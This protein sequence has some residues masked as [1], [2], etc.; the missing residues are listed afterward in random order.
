MSV[1][2]TIWK[3]VSGNIWGVWSRQNSS[4][5]WHRTDSWTVRAGTE[6]M[7]GWLPPVWLHSDHAVFLLHTPSGAEISCRQTLPNVVRGGSEGPARGC[8]GA[9]QWGD[10]CTY[11]ASCTRS[12]EYTPRE[13][14]QQTNCTCVPAV[15][16]S[17]FLNKLLG[18][19]RR[20]FRSFWDESRFENVSQIKLLW[21]FCLHF[22]SKKN[23]K[24][25]NAFCFWWLLTFFLL[26][27]NGSV[28]SVQKQCFNPIHSTYI[29]SLP[30]SKDC[31]TQQPPTGVRLLHKPHM[32]WLVHWCRTDRMTVI[33]V[34]SLATEPSTESKPVRGP[35][36]ASLPNTEQSSGFQLH[37]E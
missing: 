9:Q 25:Y 19:W 11:V 21:L 37:Q 18:L 1:L 14:W 10:D 35:S 28:T 15:V 33:M 29:S 26:W 24:Q 30:T 6:Q 23:K 20:S 2:M 27:L 4:A 12:T 22:R 8:V 36:S 31:L 17:L 7:H 34:Q 3:A 5:L 13:M 16:F 32:G